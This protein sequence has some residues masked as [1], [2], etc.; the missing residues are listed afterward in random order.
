[1]PTAKRTALRER[2]NRAQ[3]TTQRAR[4]E[5]FRTPLSRTTG[6]NERI[7]RETFA[8]SFLLEQTLIGPECS[9]YARRRDCA[10]HA[11]RQARSQHRKSQNR[12][13]QSVLSSYGT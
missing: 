4:T 13:W 10:L 3:P 1:M 12:K 8:I 9:D 11:L 6:R 5:I 7:F 2:R